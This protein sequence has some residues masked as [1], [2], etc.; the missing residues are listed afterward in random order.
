MLELQQL[1]S[2]VAPCAVTM[3]TAVSAGAA[4][5]GVR[6]G[7]GL[8]SCAVTMATAVSAGAATVG[9]RGGMGLCSCAASV[10]TLVTIAAAKSES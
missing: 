5:V 4:T 7:M 9:V 10:I 6:G 3:A 8:R 2:E 1:V